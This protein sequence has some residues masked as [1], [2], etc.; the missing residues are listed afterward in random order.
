[1]NIISVSD[2][3]TCVITR[4]TFAKK[5]KRGKADMRNR[6]TRSCRF[7]DKPLSPNDTVV[8]TPE[9]IPYVARSV[10]TRPG[11][12]RPLSDPNE[13]LKPPQALYRSFNIRKNFDL[14][15]GK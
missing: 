6:E 14:L 13:P 8:K 9:V 1:M 7:A 11:T 15:M 5:I 3:P 2:F 4:G 10:A 12:R